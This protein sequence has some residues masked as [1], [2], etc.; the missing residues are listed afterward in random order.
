MSGWANQAGVA[1]Q[2][3]RAILTCLEAVD[4]QYGPVAAIC[5]ESETDAFDLE[6]LDET[7]SLIAAQQIK[8]R[9][10]SDS[11]GPAE[12][13]AILN[14]FDTVHAAGDALFGITLG[15]R[16]G[17]RGEG[18]RDALERAH[19]L[20]TT[21]P[22]LNVTGDKLTAAAATI[23]MRTRLIVDPTPTSALLNAARKQV[24]AHLGSPGFDAVSEADDIVHRLYMLV[25]ER[26][27]QPRPEDRLVVLDDVRTAFH[28]AFVSTAGRWDISTKEAYFEAINGLPESRAVD[29][30][31]RRLRTPIEQAA[32]VEA[33][34]VHLADLIDHRDHRLSLVSGQSGSGKSTLSDS[35]RRLG[36]AHSS[37]AVLLVD[38]QRYVPGRFWVLVSD[39]AAATLNR[40]S[41]IELARG[42]LADPDSILVLDSVSEI[43]EST[44]HELTAEIHHAVS[45][46]P[47]C[48]I[49]LIGRDPA[50]LNSVVPVGVERSAY[51]LVGVP[52]DGQQKIVARVVADIDSSHQAFGVIEKIRYALGSASAVPYLLEMAA[53][54]VARGFDIKGRAQMYTVFAAEMARKTGV[55]NLQ[56]SLLGLGIVF[57]E[58]LTRGLRQCDQFDWSILLNSAADRLRTSG[59]DISADELRRVAIR[60]GF[61]AYE[62]YDQIVRPAHDSLADFV[63]A[64]ALS[65]GVVDAP[66]SVD[67]NDY[68]RLRFLVE[69]AGIADE[70]AILVCRD[71]PLA[72]A[73][74]AQFEYPNLTPDAPS[75]A[76]NLCRILLPE[77][78]TADAAVQM[79]SG[80]KRNLTTLG[81]APSCYV[82]APELAESSASSGLFEFRGGPLSAAE[83]IWRAHL[84]SRLTA[85]GYPAQ[86][87]TTAEKAA[88]AVREHT[89]ETRRQLRLIVDAT[90]RADLR[91]RVLELAT[92]EPCLIKILMRRSDSEPYWPVIYLS[93]GA[94]TVEL[95]EDFPDADEQAKRG[96]G[97]VDS[98]L[99]TTPADTAR[100]LV[101]KALNDLADWRW[102]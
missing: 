51:Q 42:F 81:R 25:T 74:F 23:A 77:H 11:W 26:A 99:R 83:R 88:E 61:V 79:S 4:G 54:L 55:V 33:A 48:E 80:S 21:E 78:M 17:P 59:I 96:W 13:I 60:G 85:T 98:I 20:S 95:C 100:D 39:A 8:T 69:M 71:L 31:L 29:V 40:P 2:Q 6:L 50:V 18:L 14:S 12:I 76:T 56:I 30:D 16:L 46:R 22:L 44:R 67:S 72:V 43:P 24:I 38:A 3:A 57:S 92:P 84:D 37:T 101:R 7:K 97:S 28:G 102:L 45:S 52:P 87:P 15:G 10:L 86:I 53:Q 91:T 75:I 64:L 70:I 9:Q 41:S 34:Q 68:L 66:T 58:L 36:A 49:V 32:G 5:V 73:E 90:I 62:D 63:S 35:M 89:A 65:K 82:S 27:S 93:S 1:Y 94:T 19:A 47:H